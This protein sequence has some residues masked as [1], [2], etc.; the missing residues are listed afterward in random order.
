[1]SAGPSPTASPRRI[2]ATEFGRPLKWVE[3]NSRDTRENAARTVALLRQQGIKHIVLVTHGWH[4]PRAI[5][6][7]EEAAPDMR[8][9][10]APMGLARRLEHPALSWIP[11]STGAVDVRNILRELLGRLFGV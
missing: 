11:S 7:F 8:I 2:A 10:P 4:M 9:E 6:K 1:M 5:R 3:D